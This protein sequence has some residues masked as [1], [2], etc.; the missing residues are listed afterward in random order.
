MFRL[1]CGVRVS[2]PQDGKHIKLVK[3]TLSRIGIANNISK[4]LYPSAY[5]IEDDE[6]FIIAHFKEIFPLINSDGVCDVSDSDIERRNTIAM[7]L[8]KWGILAIDEEI[9]T[10]EKF[11]FILPYKNK[12]YWTIN[13]KLN[14]RSFER[15]YE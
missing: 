12:K 13:H 15:I 6:G 1:N 11:V 2:F 10:N 7:L 9:N 14:L 8:E 4:T 5:L 3:E